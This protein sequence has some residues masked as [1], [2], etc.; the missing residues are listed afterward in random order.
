MGIRLIGP[1]AG[2]ATFLGF[3]VFIKWYKLPD[4]I[5]NDKLKNI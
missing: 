4:T 5:K 2:I 1:I 3:F